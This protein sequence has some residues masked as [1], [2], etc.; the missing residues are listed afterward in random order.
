MFIII[1]F[2]DSINIAFVSCYDKYTDYSFNLNAIYRQ[3]SELS[4]G[5]IHG[6]V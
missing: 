5:L 3:F 4:V 1:N 6:G 2:C